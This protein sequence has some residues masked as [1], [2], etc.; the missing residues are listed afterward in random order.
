LT[1]RLAQSGLPDI[2]KR[3]HQA[4]PFVGIWPRMGSGEIA[5]CAMDGRIRSTQQ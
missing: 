3:L 4:T 1:N 2:E 5:L